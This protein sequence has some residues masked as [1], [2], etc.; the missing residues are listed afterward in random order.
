MSVEAMGA[1]FKTRF[2]N[3]SARLVLFSLADH[4]NRSTGLCCPAIKT[5]VADTC[6]SRSTVKRALF[7]LEGRPDPDNPE[8]DFSPVPFILRD[9]QFDRNGRQIADRFALLFMGGVQ[10]DP[11]EGGVQVEPGE[12]F[13]REPGDGFNSE[14]PLK[15]TGISNRKK[16]NPLPPKGVCAPKDNNASSLTASP[17]GSNKSTPARAPR[18][19]KVGAAGKY[20]EKFEAGWKL[21]P[22]R[23]GMSKPKAFASWLEQGCE[24]IADAVIAGIK[25]YAAWLAMKR[26]TRPDHAVKHMQGWLTDR[27]WANGDSPDGSKTSNDQDE[28]KAKVARAFLKDGKWNNACAHIWRTEADLMAWAETNLS[29]NLKAAA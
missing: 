18:N 14:P 6:L 5:I 8:R 4:H 15:R 29:G 10:V 1:A 28:F 25:A 12:G 2:N 9:E 11:L 21:F 3:P 20:T 16:E 27:R 13:T 23:I 7:W 22:D 19:R 24:E 17:E 26:K